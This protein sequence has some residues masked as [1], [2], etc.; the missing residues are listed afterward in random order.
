MLVY[1]QGGI[2]VTL[3]RRSFVQ[4]ALG[5]ALLSAVPG[6]LQAGSRTKFRIGVTDWNLKQSSQLGAVSVAKECGFAG[7]QLALG[8]EL[9]DGRLA[10]DDPALQKR[11]LAKAKPTGLR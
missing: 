5:G 6:P 7:V 11:Y 10:L 1:T 3:D 9:V 4:S 8:R 2:A